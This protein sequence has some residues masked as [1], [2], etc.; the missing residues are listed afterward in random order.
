MKGHLINRLGTFCVNK[1]HTV[2]FEMHVLQLNKVI[3]GLVMAD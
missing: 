3:R 2:V 1:E